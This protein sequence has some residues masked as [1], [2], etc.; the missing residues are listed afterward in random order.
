[1]ILK[2]NCGK[3]LVI[4]RQIEISMHHLTRHL[5]DL[6][7]NRKERKKNRKKINKRQF[8][9]RWRWPILFHLISLLFYF[10]W[11]FLIFVCFCFVLYLFVAAAQY[12]S[13]DQYD[14]FILK[15]RIKSNFRVGGIIGERWTKKKT[16]E[17]LKELKKWNRSKLDGVHSNI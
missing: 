17:Q 13:L 10:C 3:L 1:M 11:V 9:Q 2:I 16:I 4:V 7:K 15:Q 6:P 12:F 8:D 14:E 5:F